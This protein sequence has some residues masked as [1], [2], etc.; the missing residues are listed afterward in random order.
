VWVLD[1]QRIG[2]AQKLAWA[3]WPGRH[4]LTL[5][6]RSGETIQTV[7]FEVRGAGLK[8]TALVEADAGRAPGRPKPARDPAGVDQRIR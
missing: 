6:D 7:R 1:G 8:A 4:E 5:Q 3:P 2:A